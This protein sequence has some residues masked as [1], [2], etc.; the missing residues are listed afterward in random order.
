LTV[1]ASEIFD[2]MSEYLRKNYPDIESFTMP[3]CSLSEDEKGKYYRVQIS[4]KRK[5]QLWSQTAIARANADNGNIE[6][7]KE[8]F[9]WTF[10]I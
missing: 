7:F 10:W 4:F 8:G 5:G 2:K 9:T 6:M 3:Y 1:G